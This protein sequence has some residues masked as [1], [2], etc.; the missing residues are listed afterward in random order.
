MQEAHRTSLCGKI[1]KVEQLLTEHSDQRKEFIDMSIASTRLEAVRKY[2]KEHGIGGIYI[3]SPENFFYFSGY[4][5]PDGYMVITERRAAA[6]SDFRYIEAAREHT[7]E[8]CEVHLLG[9]GDV[10][11]IVEADN[12]SVLAFEDELLSVSDYDLLS[13]QLS[14]TSCVTVKLGDALT[15]M[16]A[17]KDDFEVSQIVSAQRIAEGA[18]EHLLKVI[19]HDMTEIEVAAELEYYM[20][21]HG[22]EN[23]SFDTIA[24]SGKASS[25]PHGTPRNSRL[26]EGF[27]TLDFGAKIGAYHS[28]MTRTVVIGR[29]DEEMRRLYKTV[30]EAQ[31]AGI[32]AVA[33][34]RD[35]AEIDRVS[36]DIIDGAGYAGC[37]GH[38]LGHGVGLEIHELPL[39]SR[40]GEGVKLAPGNIVTVEPGIYIEGKYGC[41]IEDMVLVTE[42]GGVDLTECRSELIEL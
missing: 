42:D 23:P 40:R 5:N 32:E 26:E 6:F 15:I 4:N 3:S 28:D 9:D 21:L 8:E 7:F 25:V 1:Q 18:F 39:L 41:R 19:R 33:A 31:K 38:G 30:L 22:S 10:K 34:G 36:R 37:F 2:M 11:T 29:A 27:L 20:K 17:V 14:D 16:R 35:C 12:V 24:V 13:D